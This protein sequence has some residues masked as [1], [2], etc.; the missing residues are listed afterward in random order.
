MNRR[1]LIKGTAVLG[2][3]VAAG[4][5]GG[6]LWMRDGRDAWE[7]EVEAVRRAIAPGASASDHTR[8]LVRAA[9]LAANS[10][11]TQPWRFAA[12][13]GA[14]TIAPDF[15][16]RC[17]VV[18][19]DDHH[20][21]ASLGCATENMVQAAPLIGLAADARFDAAMDAVTVGLQPGTV[22]SSG[23]G[24]AI[25]RRQCARSLYDG[26]AV[27]GEQLKML[28]AA[29]RGAGVEIV[30]LTEP[31]AVED[32][33]ALI[34]EGNTRQVEDPA[35]VAELK[36]WL[37]FSYRDAVDT[38]DGLFSAASGSPV[39][40]GLVGNLI[41][42]LVFTARGENARYAAQ[43]RSSS[44][45]AVFVSEHDDKT[46]W[47]EAGRAVERFALTATTLGLSHA[48]VN[49]VVEV[50]EVRHNLAG[51]LGLGDRRPD[52]VV[53][54]GYGPDMPRSLRRPVDWHQF[55]RGVGGRG[56]GLPGADPRVLAPSPQY[57]GRLR[58]PAHR[59]CA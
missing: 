27:P 1:Q 30:I 38:R 57:R 2:G 13:D 22:Q 49:Q 24:A 9:T 53:R 32:V 39:I 44:G 11:N 36:R 48:F 18:D 10:H 42:G 8:A 28:E 43:V 55:V 47:V 17:A 45:L 12:G 16:R 56:E 54:F 15:A 3:V 7:A 52:F 51:R 34:I 50:A 31:A 4:G 40:P 19:P 6:V 25:V 23:L 37:R 26:R 59:P 14:I 35:F 58:R 46:H 33:L 21:Y 20:L 41:F 29:G 5:V